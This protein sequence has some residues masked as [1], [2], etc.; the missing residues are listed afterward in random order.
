MRNERN[1][2]KT[3]LKNADECY[4]SEEETSVRMSE[5]DMN[6]CAKV[7]D[8]KK[9][10]RLGHGKYGEVWLVRKKSTRAKYAMKRV[11]IEDFKNYTR[12]E[13]LEAEKNVFSV[14]DS[15]YLVK[16]VY[17]FSEGNHH[18]FVMEYMPNGDFF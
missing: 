13:D 1:R 11:Y 9:I 18:Y 3:Q 7:K 14:I 15:P 16:A 17:S 2:Y 6:N 4:F 8:F 5:Q 12:L 10:K